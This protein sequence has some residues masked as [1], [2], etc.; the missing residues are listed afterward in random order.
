[1][2]P[3]DRHQDPAASR[4]LLQQFVAL[5]YIE[6]PDADAEKAVESAEREGR[7]NLAQALLDAR[8]P[9]EA[10]P[11]LEELH[12]AESARMLL[13]LTLA[14]CYLALG[15]L[16]DSRRIVEALAQGARHDRAC[17]VRRC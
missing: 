8:R 16:T 2:H 11:L 1:M 4:A 17:F 6:K 15:R 9:A 3:P 12:A 7:Y 14:N 13:S 5:G 10:L